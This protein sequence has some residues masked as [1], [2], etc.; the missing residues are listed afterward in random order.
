MNYP[1]YFRHK[2]RPASDAIVIRHE[3]DTETVVQTLTGDRPPSGHWC[4]SCSLLMVATG[5]AVQLTPAEARR[6]MALPK[7][8]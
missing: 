8:D 3:S 4:V 5:K 6:M 7:W 1:L 2:T